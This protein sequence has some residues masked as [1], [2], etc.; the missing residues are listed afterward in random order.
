MKI[1]EVGK[2]LQDSGKVEQELIQK[3]VEF[4]HKV[5]NVEEVSMTLT[6]DN[7]LYF[8]LNIIPS[9]IAVYCEL[10][11][12]DDGDYL[13]GLYSMFITATKERYSKYGTHNF[14][15]EQMLLHINKALHENSIRF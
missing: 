1:S 13:E 2:Y 10:F 7:S 4:L 6:M 5:P 11:L 12:E 9:E 14:L 15:L 8:I 3:I